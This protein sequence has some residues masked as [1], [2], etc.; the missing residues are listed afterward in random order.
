MEPVS[1]QVLF[2]RQIFLGAEE[3]VQVGAV[4]PHMLRNICDM[5]V[6]HVVMVDIFQGFL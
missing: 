4:Y 2:G 6:I 5:D 1:D 3:A